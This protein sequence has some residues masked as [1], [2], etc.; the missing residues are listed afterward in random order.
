MPSGTAGS[1]SASAR[2]DGRCHTGELRASVGRVDPGA[3]QRNFPVVL[4]NTSGRTCTV[5]GYP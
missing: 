2:T 3:G 1:A 5:H 4:T